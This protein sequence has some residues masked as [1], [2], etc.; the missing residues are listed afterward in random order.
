MN[1]HGFSV[2][3][4][5]KEHVINISLSEKGGEAVFFEGVLGK[6]E[7]LEVIDEAVLCIT[8]TKGTL[9][10][11]LTNEELQRRRT[12]TRPRK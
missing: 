8:G 9:M 6:L 12:C 4:K 3:L 7:D 5:S 2:R 11:D 1:E 10:V